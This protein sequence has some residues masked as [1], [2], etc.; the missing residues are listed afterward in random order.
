[1][2]AITL[3][4]LLK[5]V[6]VHSEKLNDSISDDHLHEI[7][8]FLT[9]WQTVAS[10]LCLS[11]IDRDAIE[12]EGKD[13]EDKKRKALQK[14]KGKYAFKATYRKL[15]EALLSLAKADVAEKVCHLLKGIIYMYHSYM[16]IILTDIPC[17]IIYHV[18]VTV[19]VCE[20]LCC[21]TL[22]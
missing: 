20:S 12:R 7:A 9:S 11:E 19:C 18:C 14:W 16:D 15:V 22:F 21:G 1:M 10:K 5:E 4:E 2:A 13:E 8:L 6:G 3:E 17:I